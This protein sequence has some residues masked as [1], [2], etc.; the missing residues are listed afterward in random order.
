MNEK[1]LLESF[2]NALIMQRSFNEFRSN[3]KKRLK[4]AINF[5]EDLSNVNIKYNYKKCFATFD[6]ILVDSN[7]IKYIALK[8]SNI[9][10]D[11]Y[12]DTKIFYK[13]KLFVFRFVEIVKGSVAGSSFVRINIPLFFLDENFLEEFGE[14][15]KNIKLMDQ[16]EK[17]DKK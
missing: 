9:R 11:N 14:I 8:V 13:D 12:E 5:I 17:S 4:V 7:K 15:Y 10:M 16:I 2:E 1:E 6:R 3:M